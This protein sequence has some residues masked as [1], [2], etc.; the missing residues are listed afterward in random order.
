MKMILALLA[1]LS[2]PA[3]AQSVRGT[4]PDYCKPCLFYGG[5]FDPNGPNPQSVTNMDGLVIQ[6][7]TYVPF[8]IPV[9]QWTITGLF[10]NNLATENYINPAKIQWSIS[11]GISAGNPG[12]LIASGTA[13][14]T[15]KPT[16]RR[17]RG[18]EEFTALGHLTPQ[19]AVTLTGP[20]VYWMSAVPMCTGNESLCSHAE[21]GVTDV[22]DIPAPNHKGIQPSNDAFFTESPDYYVPTW[23]PQGPCGGN[24]CNKFSAG[25]LGYAK[26]SN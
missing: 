17:W 16:G 13:F 11:S 25:L 18:Q 5:D 21:Y 7:T 24:G 22:E 9:G 12:T 3:F 20:A 26:P 8:Y 23:E 19:Q 6:A 2:I 10:S 14:A 15:W 4:P 1:L